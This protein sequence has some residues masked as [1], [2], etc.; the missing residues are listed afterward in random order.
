MFLKSVLA[1]L[2]AGI[3]EFTAKGIAQGRIQKDG[4]VRPSAHENTTN[5]IQYSKPSIL[6]VPE[7]RRK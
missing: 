1:R 4:Q 6:G 5:G 3:F 7:A 2:S